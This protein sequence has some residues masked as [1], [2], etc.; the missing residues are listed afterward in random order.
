MTL[1][2]PNARE[3]AIMTEFLTP[4]LT[5]K[6]YSNDVTPDGTKVAGDFTEVSGGG[7]TSFPLTFANWTIVGGAPTVC[8]YPIQG[9]GFTGPTSAPGT[10]YGYFITRVSDGV[11]MYAERFPGGTVPFTPENGSIIRVTPKITCE[12]A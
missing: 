8:T 7:Y 6:L 9:W 12:S 3:V 1:I 2:V 4:S 11:L 10:I 5:L